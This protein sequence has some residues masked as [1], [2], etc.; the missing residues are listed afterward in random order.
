MAEKKIT[1]KVISKAVTEEKVTK[2]E[3]PTTSR[4]RKACVFCQGET[5]PSYTDVVVLRRFLSDRAKIMPKLKS[6]LCSRHQRA[7]T[8]HIKYA[9]HLALLPFVP[10]V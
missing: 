10:K 6:N 5:S 9:R 4:S 8:K 1:R 3:E 2:V 7:V